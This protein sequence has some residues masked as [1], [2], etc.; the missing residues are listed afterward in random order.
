MLQARSHG[1]MMD[2][3]VADGLAVLC[4]TPCGHLTSLN[5]SNIPAERPLFSSWPAALQMLGTIVEAWN[6]LQVEN[7]VDDT[8]LELAALYRQ[9][10]NDVYVPSSPERKG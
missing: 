3:S 4:S 2:L 1:L 8:L 9:H 5:V 10:R 7:S 6:C